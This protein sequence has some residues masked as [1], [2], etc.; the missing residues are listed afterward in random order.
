MMFCRAAG[1]APSSGAH[2]NQG[3]VPSGPL[4]RAG[5]DRFLEGA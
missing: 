2:G 5:N 3:L 4:L 1:Q